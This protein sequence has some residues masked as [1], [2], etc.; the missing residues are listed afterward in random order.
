L[1]GV[2]SPALIADDDEFFRMA[3]RTL[4]TANLEFREV[5][6]TSSLDDALRALDERIG[7]S[8]ALFD[9]DMPGMRSAASLRA[10]REC[11]PDMRIAV[12]SASG[13]RRDMLAALEAGVHG[14]VPKSLGAGELSRALRL[15]VDGV[16]YVPSSIS[17]VGNDD[18][19][20]S[21]QLSSRLSPDHLSPRQKQVLE[22]LVHGKSNKEIARALQLSEGT[23]KVHMAAVFR[24]LS[25]TTR[26]AA[27]VAGSELLTR[28]A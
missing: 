19:E 25:V 2:S 26:A 17:V 22:L 28:S 7:I 1:N 13:K 27:A 5:I 16:I 23:V 15:I 6:E 8:L 18:D 11:F 3:L 20:Q 4:L 14:Y 24:L 10:V 21:A 9:L 12:V